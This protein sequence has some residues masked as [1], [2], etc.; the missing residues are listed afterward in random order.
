[1][2]E[3]IPVTCTTCARSFEYEQAKLLDGGLNAQGWD[4]RGGNRVCPGCRSGTAVAAAP[5]TFE[6]AGEKDGNA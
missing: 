4:C 6:A 3:P 2:G 5:T 1:M